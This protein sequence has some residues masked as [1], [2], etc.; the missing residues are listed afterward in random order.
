MESPAIVV[1]RL[2]RSLS[3]TFDLTLYQA[4]RDESQFIEVKEYDRCLKDEGWP[5]GG[6]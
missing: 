2:T 5:K 4:P 3:L 1:L 6:I